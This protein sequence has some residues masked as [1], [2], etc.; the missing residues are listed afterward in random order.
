[1]E[2]INL[3]LPMCEASGSMHSMHYININKF[4]YCP[5]GFNLYQR[6]GC[7]SSYGKMIALILLR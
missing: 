5:E 2:Q 1:M 7:R 3:R 6:R 4:I